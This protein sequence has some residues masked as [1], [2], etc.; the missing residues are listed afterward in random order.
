MKVKVP[1][2]CDEMNTGSKTTPGSKCMRQVV[3]VNESESYT[4]QVVKVHE[5]CT[6]QVA[7]TK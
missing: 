5:S 7:V 4:W 6:R 3:K 2:S 1:G